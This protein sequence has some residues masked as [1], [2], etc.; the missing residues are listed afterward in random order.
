MDIKLRISDENLLKKIDE[1][2]EK[3]GF[4]SRN[5]FINHIIKLYITS[6]DTFFLGA[7]SPV[8][9]EICKENI[10]EQQ[11]INEHLLKNIERIM[12]KILESTTD[13]RG[14]FYADLTRNE[15]ENEVSNDK[16]VDQTILS[17]E[18]I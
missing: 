3:E 12:I 13:I 5:Q 18:D 11:K 17:S 8:M 10:A 9:R 1:A 14:I 2:I 7:F 16:D 4:S 15:T 6:R